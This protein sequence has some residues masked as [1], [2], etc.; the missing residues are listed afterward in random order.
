MS[1]A[2]VLV[3]DDS[4]FAR[5]VLRE[6]LNASPLIEVV[7]IARDGLE[8]LEKVI[9]LQPDVVTLDLM[10]PNLDGLGVLRELT[11][12]GSTVRVILVSSSDRDSDL[13]VE[14]LRLGAFDVVKKP[15]S[16]ATDVL[17]ELGDELVRKVVAARASRARKASTWAPAAPSRRMV[18]GGDVEL[19]VIG[20][21]TGGPNALTRVL[22]GLP[23]DF[24]VP[25][26]IALHIPADYTPA[27]AARLND[28]CKLEVVEGGAVTLLG[29]GLVVL[30]RGGMHMRVVRRAGSLITM[31]SKEP[32][33]ADFFPSVDLLFESAAAATGKRTLGVVLTGMGN[34]GTRGARAIV[35]AGGAVIS[36]AEESCVVYGMPRCVAE[37]GLSSLVVPIDRVAEE[38]GRWLARQHPRGE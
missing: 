25:I 14:A 38:L 9:E 28:D 4:A 30:A 26:A 23:A 3:V 16:L 34:D 11:A 13:V 19:V 29:P 17:Y 36:E 6:S 15:T 27:L 8:A 37:A 35:E 10:M 5:K 2:R 18:T 21:S 33:N 22:A 1:I 32:S 12:S 31:M 7:G 24:P 20:T